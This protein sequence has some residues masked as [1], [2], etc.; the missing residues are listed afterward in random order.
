MR[1]MQE[2]F[3]TD[4]SGYWSD[5]QRKVRC[6]GMTLPYVDEGDLAD[7]DCENPT[8]PTFGELRLHFD[9]RTWDCPKHGLIYTDDQFEAQFKEFLE[10]EGYAADGVSYSEQG[11]QG[12]DYVSFDVDGPFIT[13]WRNK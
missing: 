4:G 11:M 8:G 12:S 6:I 9:K 3:E 7:P 13:S 5:E 2:H 1:Q 10:R